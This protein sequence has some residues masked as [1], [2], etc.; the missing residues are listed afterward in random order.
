[1]A[2]LGQLFIDLFGKLLELQLPGWLFRVTFGDCRAVSFVIGA[3]FLAGP[4]LRFG[5]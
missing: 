2:D 1:M 5:R 3:T 4:F